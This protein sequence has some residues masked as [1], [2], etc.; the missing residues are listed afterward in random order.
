MINFDFPTTIAA[1]AT[2]SIF[3]LA[4]GYIGLYINGLYIHLIRIDLHYAQ[5]GYYLYILFVVFLWFLIYFQHFHLDL[6]F[7][8]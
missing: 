4:I 5:V 7:V 8:E 6:I 1:A 2:G 3:T